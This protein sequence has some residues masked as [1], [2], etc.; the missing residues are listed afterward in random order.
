MSQ[1]QLN[2]LSINID[3]LIDIF[4]KL[5]FNLADAVVVLKDTQKKMDECYAEDNQ[6][7]LN[8]HL[9]GENIND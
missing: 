3:Y 5:Q 7:R 1:N 6:S 8:E 2:D 4:N 9:D